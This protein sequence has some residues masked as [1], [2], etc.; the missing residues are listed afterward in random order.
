MGSL[1]KLA[2]QMGS[3]Q[4]G[5]VDGQQAQARRPCGE[6]ASAWKPFRVKGLAKQADSMGKEGGG[7]CSTWAVGMGA[8]AIP[9][10]HLGGAWA[11]HGQRMRGAWAAHGRRVG[12]AWAAHGRRMGS[13][14]VAHG[15]R[16]DGAW[17][18]HGWRMGSAWTAH[19]R[20]MGG[21]WAV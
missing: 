3:A 9:G 11:A 20:R 18:A 21:A 19:G 8:T 1:D 12:S 7:V 6:I 2:G 10:V 4:L 16:M 5:Q 15:Q 13:A 14:C 17:A